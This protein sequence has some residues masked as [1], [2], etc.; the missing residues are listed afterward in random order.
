MKE[1]NAAGRI[2]VNTLLRLDQGLVHSDVYTS[3][4][5]FDLEMEKIYHRSWVYVGH[6]SEIPE[7]GDYVLR[8]IGTQSVIMSRDDSGKMHLFMNRCRHRAN[9]VCQFEKG[10]SSYFRCSYHGWTYGNTGELVGVPYKDG[11]Y[12]PDFRKEDFPLVSARM[13]VYRGFIWGN[14]GPEG[15]SLDEHLGPAGKKAIDHFCDASPEGEI[16]LRQGCLKGLIYANWKFQGGD[17]Y[18]PGV[19]HQANFMFMRGKREG[20]RRNPLTVNGKLE[21]GFKSRDLGHGHYSLDLRSIARDR[22]PDTAWARE[23]RESMMKAYGKE[24]AEF[25]IRTGG[26]PHAV[27]MP[28]MQLVNFDV[29]VL[30]PISVDE[31]EVYFY[32]AF[33]KGVPHEINEMRLRDTEDR[34]GPSGSINPDDVDMFERNQFGMQQ[35][36]NPWKFMARGI[37]REH[38]DDDVG[39]PEA[40]R[41]T[42]TLTSH[43]SDETTQRAQLR[44]WAAHLSQP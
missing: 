1:T 7:P 44:W 12:A 19:T 18:H 21:D 3:P 32:C 39:T 17:G 35:T 29:R 41:M 8:W 5:V 14:L 9:S 22:L 20:N 36:V 33:L 16:I 4:K 11:A 27:F 30:R 28:N 38:I 34:M 23:Y 25:L 40:Y 43:Y 31:F 6:E 37:D 24:R 26:N 2:D 13:E 10:N 15:I 42:G